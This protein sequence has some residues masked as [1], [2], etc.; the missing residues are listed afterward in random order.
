MA[1]Y[2]QRSQS[3]VD[4][5]LNKSATPTQVDRVGTAL[6]RTANRISEYQAGTS[7]VKAQILME[8]ARNFIINM[9][10]DTEARAAAQAAA[11]AAVINT[12]TD[13]TEGP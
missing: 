11:N 3:Y 12:P 13:F 5:L 2:V 7:A 6:A 1:T 8:E 10:M 9:V 4:A